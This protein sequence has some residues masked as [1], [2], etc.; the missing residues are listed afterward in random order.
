MSG[1]HCLAK[2]LA[3]VFVL[4]LATM[5]VAQVNNAQAPVSFPNDYMVQVDLVYTRVGSWEGRLDLYY[6]SSKDQKVPLVIN[7]HG[8]G[9]N[10]GTKESQ[11]GFGSF[12]KK[13]FAVA[14]VEYRLVHEGEAPAAVQDVRCALNYL[15]EHAD[16]FNVDKNR[17]ILMGS[18]AGAHLAM[19]AGL[20]K[21]NTIFDVY[22]KPEKDLEVF[23]IINKY[24]VSDLTSENVRKSKS[25][26]NWLGTH[27]HD[28]KFVKSVSP[29]YHV[30]KNSPPI[31]IVH[32]DADPVVPYSQSKKLY[33]A[34]LDNSVKTKLVTIKN[35]KHGKFSKEDQ[36]NS[37]DELWDFLDALGL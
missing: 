9:W 23:A 15:Y 14:N 12:F 33:Q 32:G 1:L 16:D 7:I 20:L 25:V 4:L 35:G 30:D 26:K 18:S 8:G 19:L 34:L 11:T 36:K 24:G 2:R 3:G 29:I 5:A 6:P 22:C 27:Y 28:V 13:G 10:H 37:N 21:N 17:I 31:F